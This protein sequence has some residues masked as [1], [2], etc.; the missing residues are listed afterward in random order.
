MVES[1]SDDE[2][3]D[4]DKEGRERLKNRRAACDKIMLIFDRKKVSKDEEVAPE[5]R[6][7]KMQKLLKKDKLISLLNTFESQIATQQ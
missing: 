1:S 5:S 6:S 2:E 4:M 3:S 7:M